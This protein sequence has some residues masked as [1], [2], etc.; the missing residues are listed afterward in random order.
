MFDKDVDDYPFHLPSNAVWR[1]VLFYTGA[2]TLT[3]HPTPARLHNGEET[4]Q[5]IRPLDNGLPKEC[6]AWD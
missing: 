3:G 1:D 2:D 6:E 4:W 5:R